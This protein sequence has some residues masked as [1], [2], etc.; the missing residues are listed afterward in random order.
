MPYIA[1]KDRATIDASPIGDCKLHNSRELAYAIIQL[2]LQYSH[3]DPALLQEAIGTIESA[4]HE[5]YRKY[6]N[7]ASAQHEF[8][9]GGE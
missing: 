1:K 4:K 9:H 6:V 2:T 3:N 8:D 5:I 7:P